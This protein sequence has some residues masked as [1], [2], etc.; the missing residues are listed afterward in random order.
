MQKFDAL[1]GRVRS[2]IPD[3]LDACVSFVLFHNDRQEITEAINQVRAEAANTHIVI[4]DNS[5]P[6]L[7]LAFAEASD[8]TIAAT[9]ENIG[10]GRGHNI[11]L[12]ASRGKC[13]YNVV[14]NTDLKT[15]GTV[16]T[17]MIAFMDRHPEAGLAMPRICY[18]D[19]SLQRLCRLLPDPKDIVARR[20][21]SNTE[22][23]R[24]RNKRYEFHGWNYDKV[25]E[26][27]FLSGCFM[28]L[29]RS[30][31]EVTGY[32]DERFFLYA[33][34]L[35]LS[36]RIGLVSKTLFNPEE[37][38]V[39]EYRSKTNPSFARKRYALTSMIKY[40]NKWGWVDHAREKINNETIMKLNE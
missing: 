30:I 6:A 24:N 21:L 37:E 15:D 29:R 16:I 23:G 25:A 34:D 26:F 39:H 10:Y 7:D 5:V 18:P 33:E 36:R 13:R 3:N 31:L 40:F 12:S 19:G 27:P 14:M 20:V 22:W 32:F 38:A 2:A 28:V 17:G 35:D 8:V 9:N 4:V 11:A 1:V